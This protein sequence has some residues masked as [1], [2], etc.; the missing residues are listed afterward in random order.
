MRLRS[1]LFILALAC[2][3]GGPLEHALAQQLRLLTYNVKGNGVADWTTNNP[4]VQALGRKLT[5]LQPDVV[6]FQEIPY[7]NSYQMQG[8]TAAYLPGYYLATNSGTDGFIRSMIAS[9]YPIVRSQK[10]LDDAW[11]AA[12]GVNTNFTRDLF[13]AEINVPFYTERLHVFTT[14]LKAGGTSNDFARRGG[15]AS[16]IS[17]FFM[18]NFL[19][20]K[21]GRPY[22][23]TGDM[24]EDATNTSSL[25]K[26]PITRLAN[27]AT[28]LRL[29]A[30]EN[31]V[32]RSVRTYSIQ[33]SLSSRLDYVLPGGLLYSN[34]AASE[35]FRSD[36]LA[37]LPPSLL[38]TDSESASDHL[39]VLMVFNNPYETPFLLTSVAMSNQLYRLDWRASPGQ[40][41][42][43]QASFDL[44]NWM[45]CATNTQPNTRDYVAIL[46]VTGSAAF[47]RITK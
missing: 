10:W 9:R 2:V 12:Y 46:S 23:L 8:V 5:H 26:K 29:T 11:L 44:T 27:A 13:E 3:P 1:F 34:I 38:A 39:P 37:P 22:V 20:T 28:G 32:T 17:N 15:E 36:V 35:V 25:S 47:F 24:N 42:Y 45:V 30:P 7:T 4:Q 33:A 18:T 16:A 21:A 43:L 6:T 14:H 41:F 40:T 19:P 31:P